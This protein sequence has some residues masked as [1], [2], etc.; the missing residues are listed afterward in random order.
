MI[1]RVKECYERYEQE[2]LAARQ[3]AHPCDG[4]FGFGADPR[5]DPCH[6]RFYQTVGQWVEEFLNA[7]PGPEAC[8][9][10]AEWILKAAD[11]HREEQDVYWYMYAAQSHALPLIR[12]MDTERSKALLNWYET[13]YPARD[14]MPAQDA[15]YKAL[16]K[17]SRT[18][19]W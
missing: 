13:A 15:V 3:R 12:K 7:K 1:Q 19:L 16:K 10:A 8:G 4:L 18:K 14:R 17:A 2:A 11:I 6:D 9:E 5:R